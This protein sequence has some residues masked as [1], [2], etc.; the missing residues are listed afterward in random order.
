MARGA[1]K[2]VGNP[3]F[4][5]GPGTGRDGLAGAAFAS[6]DLTEESAEQQRAPCR[7]GPVH[8]ETV[9]GSLP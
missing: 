5:V 6:Q 4:Y 9:H 7:W 3:V 1:A 8:G 2:G